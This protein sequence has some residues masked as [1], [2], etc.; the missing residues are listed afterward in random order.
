[1]KINIYIQIYIYIHIH[2][3]TYTYISLP[4]YQGVGWGV[5]VHARHM[6]F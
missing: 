3:Y 6:A 4:N 2:T 5:T 1:M